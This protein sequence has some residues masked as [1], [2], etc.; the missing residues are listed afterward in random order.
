[1]AAPGHSG[2]TAVASH[3]A[4]ASMLLT[5]LPGELAE[6]LLRPDLRLLAQ[7]AAITFDP[8][9]LRSF[10]ADGPGR[11]RL[12]SSW[13]AA[14]ASFVLRHALE[15]SH[16]LGEC[17]DRPALAGLA[18]ARTAA[19]FLRLEQLGRE[20]TASM[21]TWTVPLGEPAPPDQPC[22]AALWR[23][24]AVHQPGVAPT[25]SD[26]DYVAWLALWPCLGPAEWIMERGGDAR[27][28]VDPHT[29]LNGYGS[30][31]RPRPWAVTYASSTASSVSERGYAGAEAARRRIL[32]GALLG[33]P[34]DTEATAIRAELSA[35]YDL[36]SGSGVVLAASGTD[37]ELLALALVQLEPHPG[38]ITSLL[39]APE[40]TG[41]GVPLA[42]IGRHFANDTARGEAVARGEVVEG[43]RPDTSLVGVPLR[44]ADGSVRQP[45]DVARQCAAAVRAT[46]GR[47]AL[48]LLDVSKTGLL[49]P[50]EDAVRALQRDWPGMVDVVVDACQ[51][52]LSAAR[53]RHY[54]EA[55]WI[56]LVTGSKFF[57]GPPFAGAM[58][59]PAAILARLRGGSLPAGLRHYSARAEWPSFAATEA[60]GGPV[61]HGLLLRWQAALAEMRAF[62]AVTPNQ[63]RDI[64]MRFTRNVQAGIT[65][66]PDLRL[67]PAPPLARGSDTAAWDTI[68]TI[69][70]FALRDPSGVG[71]LGMAEAR[72]VYRWLNA[73]LSAPL[74]R[75]LTVSEMKTTGLRCHIGQPVSLAY[76][77]VATGA[78]RISAG[79]RLVSGEPSHGRLNAERRLIR[80]IDDVRGAMQSFAYPAA[81]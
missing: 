67:L 55:G 34:A 79:A 35:H 54:V 15:L 10:Q 44:E 75:Y 59:V 13:S 26:S 41:S 17:P 81:P 39:M 50:Q 46:P 22:A 78:L 77:G 21:P 5:N 61:N 69:I 4:G 36:P 30:S 2:Q 49:A 11:V 31:H 1:M 37:C 3:D 74:R 14:T 47:V 29:G 25:L 57:T 80:E 65:A 60:L 18:A 20:P 23:Q 70:T 72:D 9:L 7:G 58:L 24:L 38:A 73:D 51:A 62:S 8:A 28:R 48:H 42:A 43:F 27:L 16:L 40:E 53:V 71:W 76:E 68:G 52:R 45:G 64:L 12:G 32:R 19:L 33:R 56:V 66:N 6:T 63:C